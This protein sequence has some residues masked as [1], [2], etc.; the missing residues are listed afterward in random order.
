MESDFKFSTVP[1]LGRASFP[2]ASGKFC[3][4]DVRGLKIWLQGQ[5]EFTVR[6]SP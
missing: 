1:G 4:K 6:S 2:Q 5:P 3:G